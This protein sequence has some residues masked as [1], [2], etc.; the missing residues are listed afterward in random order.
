MEGINGSRAGMAPKNRKA[1]CS[2]HHLLCCE[3]INVICNQKTCME[4]DRRGG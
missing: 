1:L 4:T 2:A 3:L